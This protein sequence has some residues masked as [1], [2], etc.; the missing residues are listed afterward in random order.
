MK[1]IPKAKG[2]TREMRKIPTT[3]L[4]IIARPPKI[5]VTTVRAARRLARPSGRETLA[6]AKSRLVAAAVCD[7][8]GENEQTRKHPLSVFF[9]TRKPQGVGGIPSLNPASEGVS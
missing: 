6:M 4:T 5:T 1:E 2:W 9:W 7:A 3:N 8:F